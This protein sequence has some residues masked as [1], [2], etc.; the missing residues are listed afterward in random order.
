MAVLIPVLFQLH[1]T[2]GFVAF[3]YLTGTAIFMLYLGAISLNRMQEGHYFLAAAIFG[4][5]GALSIGLASLVLNERLADIIATDYHPEA[6][7]FL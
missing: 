5:L 2:L 3:G 1:T 4:M 6:E 7:T